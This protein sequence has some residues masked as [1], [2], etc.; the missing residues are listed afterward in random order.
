M[1]AAFERT[2]KN[3]GLR[4]PFRDVARPVHHDVQAER[5]ARM[6]D[7]IAHPE[8]RVDEIWFKLLEKSQPRPADDQFRPRGRVVLRA[9]ANPK[10]LQPRAFEVLTTLKQRGLRHGIISNAQFYTPIELSEL[11][12]EASGGAIRTY[13]SVFDPTLVFFSFDIGVAK[14][15]F[16]IFRRAAEELTKQRVILDY[17]MFIGDSPENDIAPRHRIGFRAVLCTP[18]RLPDSNVKPESGDSQPGATTGM[19][20]SRSTANSGWTMTR[21]AAMLAGHLERY[22]DM[23]QF[24]P[25]LAIELTGSRLA[26]PVLEGRIRAA[27]DPRTAGR[28]QESRTASPAQTIAAGKLRRSRPSQAR[29]PRHRLRR[30]RNSPRRSRNSKATTKPLPI[31]KSAS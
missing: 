18:V 7:G 20:L 19:A 22:K 24:R 28:G 26:L 31:F 29:P 2:A 5:A 30:Q 15:D 14:P 8:I 27:S 25:L 3:F 4:T 23:E 12:R 21:Q 10:Q 16:A 13:E 6:A 9:H 11:L 17:W 1:R